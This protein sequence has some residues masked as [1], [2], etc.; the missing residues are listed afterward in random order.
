MHRALL[1]SSGWSYSTRFRELDA[2]QKWGCASPR[3]FDEM[4]KGERIDVLA[5]YEVRW[6]IDAVNAHEASRR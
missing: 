5:W 3:T 2:A 1:R 6:R 4:S